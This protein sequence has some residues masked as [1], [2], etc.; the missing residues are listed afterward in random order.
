MELIALK[1]F[2]LQHNQNALQIHN[3]H[4]VIAIR[5]NIFA[6]IMLHVLRVQAALLA[7]AILIHQPAPHVKI[8]LLEIYNV[9]MMAN[10]VTMFAQHHLVTPAQREKIAPVLALQ[11]IIVCVQVQINVTAMFV[12]ALQLV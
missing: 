7:Y 9:S 6:L 8:H 1:V 2:A 4:L 12:I 5:L 11:K 10:A 3:V